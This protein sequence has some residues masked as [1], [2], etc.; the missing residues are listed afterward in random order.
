M[1]L[2]AALAQG[3]SEQPVADQPGSSRQEAG[4]ERATPPG[5]PVR[6]LEEPEQSEDAKRQEKEAA[7]REIEDLAA[8]KSMAE[9]TEEIVF[10]T[11]LQ[12]ALA[13]LGTCALI[14][15]L[16][17]NR[18]ATNAAVAAA[19]AARDAIGVERAWLMWQN[20]VIGDVKDSEVDGLFV[21]DSTYFLAVWINSGRSPAV[22]V[23]CSIQF[24]V[25]ETDADTPTFEPI[26]TD[27]GKDKLGIMGPA[28]MLTSAKRALSQFE[29]MEFR[30]RT[31]K[32]IIFSSVSY[33]DV[34]HPE[35]IRRTEVCYEVMP[36]GLVTE[37][38]KSVVD[39]SFSPVGPQNTAN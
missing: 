31:K 19:N 23:R 25:V 28:K 13:F 39:Y 8:Q 18:R 9:S 15:S 4:Q 21:K 33:R 11:M 26:Y 36:Q 6:I 24:R 1:S 16:F 37:N 38:G 20:F 22:D 2:S 30:A 3:S 35:E 32:L 12:F 5:L 29:N 14:Y 7:E 17:L 27:D 34:Y 10:W